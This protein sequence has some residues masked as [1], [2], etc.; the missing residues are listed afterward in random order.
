ML[1]NKALIQHAVSAKLVRDEKLRK[2]T[3]PDILV[4]RYM[5][6]RDESL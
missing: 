4:G 1:A 2:K 3:K 6:I 5:L